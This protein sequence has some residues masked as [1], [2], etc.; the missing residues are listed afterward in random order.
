[1]LFKKKER[2]G[3][4]LTAQAAMKIIVILAALSACTPTFN[5]REVR[6]EQA[7]LSALLPCKPDRATRVVQLGGQAVTATMAGCEAGGAMFTVALYEAS[8]QSRAVMAQEL[9][10]INQATH[11][12]LLEQG[13]FV[14]Q[15]AIYRQSKAGSGNLSELNAQEVE[16]FLAGLS[17]SGVK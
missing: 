13:A 3:V 2:S 15:A 6:F 11:S 4:E 5:W 17:M 14:A 1:M 7:G 10:R 16:M 8:L 12:K 9:V